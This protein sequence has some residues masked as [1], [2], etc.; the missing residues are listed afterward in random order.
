MH[1]GEGLVHEQH[2]QRAHH[3]RAG[4][5]REHC[6]STGELLGERVA[7]AI[8]RDELEELRRALKNLGH[9][10]AAAAVARGERRHQDVLVHRHVAEELRHLERAADAARGDLVG[11]QAI[12]PLTVEADLAAVAAIE[13]GKEV[14]RRRLARTVR[15]DEPADLAPPNRERQV[16]HRHDAAEA[17]GETP[18][19]EN[20]SA[21]RHPR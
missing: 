8:E 11:T 19:F 4:D 14:D 18:S 3:Q 6:L 5:L 2:T 15:A 17:L 7:Q 9:R 1:A 10:L 16:V 21:A 20:R 13:A 12:G